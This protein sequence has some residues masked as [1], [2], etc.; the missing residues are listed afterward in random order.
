M[1]DKTS[2]ELLR[3]TAELTDHELLGAY[4]LRFEGLVCFAVN[5]RNEKAEDKQP[6][7]IIIRAPMCHDPLNAALLLE[8][9]AK[10]CAEE[11]AEIRRENQ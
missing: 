9:C 10:R 11:A 3:V 7:D 8:M 2:D 6:L 1:S 5:P 4:G